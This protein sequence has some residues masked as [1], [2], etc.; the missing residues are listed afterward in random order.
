MPPHKPW[1]PEEVGAHTQSYYAFAEMLWTSGSTVRNDLKTASSVN[2]DTLRSKLGAF[3]IVIPPMTLEPHPQPLR[4]YVFDVEN[5]DLYNASP[6]I[7][8]T[9]DSF[10]VFVMPP[11]PRGR[12]LSPHAP[13]D[14]YRDMQAWE[15]AW[16][17]AAVDG[18]GL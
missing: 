13:P 5:A 4:I 1:K 12:P 15:S 10:Y 8:P 9:T 14:E 3:G 11:N 17:H 6:P 2:E 7:N 16:Y 18:Y